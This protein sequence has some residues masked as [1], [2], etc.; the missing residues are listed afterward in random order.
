[1]EAAVLWNDGARRQARR[2]LPERRLG[3][4]RSARHCRSPLHLL[5][6]LLRPSARQQRDAEL[7]VQIARE[8]RDSFGVYGI[9]KVWHQLEREGIPVGRDRVHR[10]MAE[11]DLEGVIRAKR[12]QSDPFPSRPRPTSLA[13]LRP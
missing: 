5:G 1:V 12:D 8:H 3:S 9:E 2:V 10:L 11:L 7:K 13:S 4:S 6:G